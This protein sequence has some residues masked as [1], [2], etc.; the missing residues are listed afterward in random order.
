M[1]WTIEK[2]LRLSGRL[3]VWIKTYL[4]VVFCCESFAS[5]DESRAPTP[6]PKQRRKSRHAK[7][8]PLVREIFVFQNKVKGFAPIVR[9]RRKE[10]I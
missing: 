2:A 4:Q 7:S 9:N 5:I 10:N 1:S 8:F 6:V 3:A